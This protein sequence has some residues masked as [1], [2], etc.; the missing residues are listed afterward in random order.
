MGLVLV[1]GQNINQKIDERS[2]TMVRCNAFAT[3][4]GADTPAVDAQL[5]GLPGREKIAG[6][7]GCP[8]RDY[9]DNPLASGIPVSINDRPIGDILQNTRRP[10][11]GSCGRNG[12]MRIIST[13][14]WYSLCRK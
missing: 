8:G 10:S 5:H 6:G 1:L 2:A 12:A 3:A 11:T 4:S 9:A 13:I 7:S 14:Q